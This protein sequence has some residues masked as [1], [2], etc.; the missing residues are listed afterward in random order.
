MDAESTQ[1]F[2]EE[3][4][5]VLSRR[6]S[7]EEARAARRQAEYGSDKYWELLRD[8]LEKSAALSELAWNLSERLLTLRD[9]NEEDQL[10][11]IRSD[12][13]FLYH[14]ERLNAQFQ[15]TDKRQ[16]MYPGR[17]RGMS[18]SLK[19]NICPYQQRIFIERVINTKDEPKC[20]RWSFVR[21]V[22][23]AYGKATFMG[24]SARWCWC[25]IRDRQ[26][27]P[28]DLRA[29]EIF[30]HSLGQQWMTY[31]FGPEARGKLYTVGNGLLLPPN[32]AEQFSQY[33]VTLAPTNHRWNDNSDPWTWKL[34]IV[35]RKGLWNELMDCGMCYGDLHNRSI[36]FQDAVRPNGKFLFFH[37]L[38]AMLLQARRDEEY[39]T[40]LNE[41]GLEDAWTDEGRVHSGPYI[42]DTVL[43]GFIEQFDESGVSPIFRTKIMAHFRPTDDTEEE[44]VNVLADID[45]QAEMAEDSE[46]EEE[47]TEYL[48]EMIK[49]FWGN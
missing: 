1:E 26:V 32:L 31:I 35:D 27:S 24:Q 41:V 9:C 12:S 47:A 48:D 28:T 20:P 15:I 36:P 6:A 4:D 42:R 44:T 43:G 29:V 23:V 49:T 14:R 3:K 45:P 40:M 30:P 46:S 11:Y 13:A 22:R 37:Y 25:T 5:L 8:V 7:L 21:D 10:G 2:L 17:E 19:P 39:G 18:P 34:V 38:C 33:R 16:L